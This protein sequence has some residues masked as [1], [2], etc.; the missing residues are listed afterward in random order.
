LKSTE[1]ADNDMK[2]KKKGQK[3]EPYYINLVEELADFEE[4]CISD[5]NYW[6]IPIPHF[7]QDDG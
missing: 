2:K 4:W 5:N 1:E 6:G 7:I 3:V